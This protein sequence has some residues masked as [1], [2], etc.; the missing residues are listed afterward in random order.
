MVRYFIFL[1]S[2]FIKKENN[3]EL[4]IRPTDKVLVIKLDEIGDFVL[5][6]PMIRELKLSMPTVQIDLL[7]KN[8]VRNIVELCPYI[9]NKY[10]LPNFLFKKNKFSK[11]LLLVYSIIYP[12]LT[13]R[14]KYDMVIVPRWDVDS[15]FSV[16]FSF[17]SNAKFRIT[18]SEIINNTKKKYNKNYDKLYTHVLVDETPKHEVERNL[19]ILKYLNISVKNNNLEIWFDKN[20]EKIIDKYINKFDNNKIISIC[21]AASHK[22][23]EWKHSNYQEI[24]YWLIQDYSFNIVIVGGKEDKDCFL[25]N[26]YGY[27]NKLM[28]LRGKLT[29]RQTA[30]ILKKSILYIG[31]DTGPMHLSAAVGTP[32]IEISAQPFNVDIKHPQSPLRF[33][34]WG[35]KYKLL[36]PKFT[37]PPCPQN[38]CV[39]KY[40]HCINN[41]SIDEVKFAVKELLHLP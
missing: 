9:E 29:L 30:L 3:K 11:L 7:T 14:K 22:R 8:I 18:Y 36:Q 2:L 20:D 4:K 16:F 35:V 40:S 24:I 37:T 34:P 39:S 17:F 33:Y 15:S 5:M 32:V 13:V 21:P 26:S 19:Y 31:N 12:L 38:M 10:Y 25:F 27:E 1:I 41:V 23:R 6:L 28:D